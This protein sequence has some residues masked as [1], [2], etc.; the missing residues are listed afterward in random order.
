MTP[1]EKCLWW[2]LHGRPGVSPRP[3]RSWCARLAGLLHRLA[4][5]IAGLR[6]SMAALRAPVLVCHGGIP[7]RSRCKGLPSSL[8][9]TKQERCRRSFK[10]S[11]ALA[12]REEA[13][14]VLLPGRDD[15]DETMLPMRQS[16]Q[17]SGELLRVDRFVCSRIA[18]KIMTGRT[19]AATSHTTC[20]RILIRRER[21][22]RGAPVPGAGPATGRTCSPPRRR[23]PRGGR[24][25]R[26]PRET[27]PIAPR[28]P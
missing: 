17:E 2:D 1:T 28:S 7:P 3:S 5:T 19:A 25:G 6:R 10:E 8:T 26:S 21:F 13:R 15:W 23:P 11:R 4:A 9:S 14:G 27:L 16:G 12:S 24:R 20:A 22:R 18:D